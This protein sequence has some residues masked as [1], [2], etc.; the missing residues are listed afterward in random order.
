MDPVTHF[1]TGACIGRAGL[2]RRTAYAT[3]AGLLAAEAADI[4]ILWSLAGPVQELKH[5]RG[6]TH[7]FLVAP[8]VAAL[9]TGV[10][11]LF[12]LWLTRRRTRRAAA[13]PPTEPGAPQRLQPVPA[14]W[15]WVYLTA[16]L[17]ALSHILLDWTTAY[18]VRPFFPFDPRWSAGSLVFIVEPVLLAILAGALILPALG[19]LIGG[20]IGARR[21]PFRGERWAAAALVAM[22]LFWGWRF[23]EQAHARSLVENA[24]LT[25]EPVLRTAFLPYPIN[26]FRWHVLLETRDSFQTAEVD[27][28]LGA[29]DSDPRTDLLF[30]PPATPATEAAKRTLLGQVY[31]DW[32]SWAVVRDMG[33]TPAPGIDPPQLPAGRAWS[34]V[35]FTDLRFTYDFL[36]RGGGARDALSAW[37]YIVDGSQ[38]AGESMSGREQR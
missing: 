16:L 29:I 12:D 27:T 35:Q 9:V 32:G 28:R 11:W 1:L 18:G 5:H 10:I 2:Q 36:G 14:R 6:I 26:P 38:E 22:V 25:T 33:Q 37:V 15:L 34:A 30:K 4:D 3:L 24:Q 21:Q 8:L 23:A 17:S 13:A 31:L 20:E 7:T 19:T